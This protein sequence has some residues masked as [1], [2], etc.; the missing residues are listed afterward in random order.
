MFGSR[1]R[2]IL[3]CLLLLLPTCLEAATVSGTL[4]D[5]TGA[6]IIGGKVEIRGGKLL[7]AITVSSDSLGHFNVPD[8][9]P[10][11]Y[12]LRAT[13]TGFEALERVVDVKDE[14]LNLEL[15]LSLPIAKEQV[16]VPGS[17]AQFANSYAI[18]RKLRSV[19]VGSAFSVEDLIFKCDTATFE[20]K[21]G[22]VTFLQP[23]NGLSRARYLWV[24][25]TLLSN[26]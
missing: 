5:S 23:V 22:T 17:N 8:L 16:T 12:S 13:S 15:E 11:S 9:K 2:Y 26:L 4:K 20:L 6:I 3:G 18:Y 14:N 19:G 24:Q 10:G 25:G 7:Q 21:R 1:S